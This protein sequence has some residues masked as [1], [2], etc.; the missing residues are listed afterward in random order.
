MRYQSRGPVAVARRKPGR[1]LKRTPEYLRGLLADHATVQA[2]FVSKFGGPASSDRHLYTAF[3]AH[4]FE[5]A[6]E[7]AGRAS[8]PD[9][10]RVLKTLRNELAEARR[11]SR[12]QERAE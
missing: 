1:P 2:W 12:Q 8:S 6:G 3:F 11:G 9:F 4:K 7:R 5:A 10:Q